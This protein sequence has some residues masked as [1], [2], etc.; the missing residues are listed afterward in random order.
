MVTLGLL[1][2]LAP[3][4]QFALGVLWYHE[5]MPPG[6]WIGFILVWIALAIFTVEAVSHHRRRQLALAAESA[7]L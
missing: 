2:Y 6:R 5:S 1:Q 7:A 3:I 4:L